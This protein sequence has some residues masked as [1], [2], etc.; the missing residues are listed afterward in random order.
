[1]LT[2]DFAGGFAAT[3]IGSVYLYFTLQIRSSALADSVGPAGIP[4]VLG[5]L[6]ILLGAILCM[7]ATYKYVKSAKPIQPEWTGQQIRILR[8]AGLLLL[9]VAYLVIVKT[10][11][12]ALSIAVLIMIT[13]LYQGTM[14]SWRVPVIAAGGGLA[15]WLIFDRLLGIAMPSGIFQTVW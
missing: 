6:M 4:K 12:Y 3:V 2:R 8:A 7:Q 14:F 11:G 5:V 15:L 1:M 13:T 10:L 9:G